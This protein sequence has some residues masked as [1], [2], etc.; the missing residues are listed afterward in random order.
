[1][2]KNEWVRWATFGAVTKA[3][4][5]HVDKKEQKDFYFVVEES[6]IQREGERGFGKLCG[7]RKD[8][9][10]DD[11]IARAKSKQVQHGVAISI[12]GV[13]SAIATLQ[14]VKKGLQETAEDA[15]E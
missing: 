9:Q 13:Q 10:E 1:M 15:A 8:K 6:A 5:H 11:A 3:V 14:A 12:G 7:A 2:Y 4:M